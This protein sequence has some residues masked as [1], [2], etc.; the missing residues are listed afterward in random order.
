ME[1]A[2]AHGFSQSTFTQHFR[3]STGMTPKQFR[4]RHQ[5]QLLPARLLESACQ[6]ELCA[7]LHLASLNLDGGLD[8][9]V[10]VVHVAH[11]FHRVG[12]DDA[13]QAKGIEHGDFAVP[14]A[15]ARDPRDTDASSC[16]G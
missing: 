14:G 1:I 4:W 12:E 9:T 11:V 3:K 6:K 10:V 2:D 8:A 7:A 16:T 15:V 5:I 13:E